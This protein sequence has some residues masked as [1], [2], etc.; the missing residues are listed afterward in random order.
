MAAEVVSSPKI[1]AVVGVNRDQVDVWRCR[2]RDE[3]LDGLG[4]R[5]VVSR[6]A[7]GRVLMPGLTAR[8]R[9]PHHFRA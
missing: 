3:G 2:C 9:Q 6:A 8:T 7:W 5:P 1:A 4:D